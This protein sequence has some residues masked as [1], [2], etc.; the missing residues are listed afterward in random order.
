MRKLV[1]FVRIS[2]RGPRSCEY[3]R[4]KSDGSN[5]IEAFVFIGEAVSRKTFRRLTKE[6]NTLARKID[7]GKNCWNFA[8]LEENVSVPISWIRK[9]EGHSMC[10]GDC[11]DSDR[12]DLSRK[13]YCSLCTDMAIYGTDRVSEGLP[14]LCSVLPH[15]SNVGLLC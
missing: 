8:L 4:N 5:H 2:P 1:C 6:K 9:R 13:A 14:G 7:K 11:I 10:V 12:V 15:A 3:I